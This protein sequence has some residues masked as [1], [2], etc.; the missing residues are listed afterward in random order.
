MSNQTDFDPFRPAD[1]PTPIHDV[2]EIQFDPFWDER[3]RR[4]AGSPCPVCGNGTAVEHGTSA[5][6]RAWIRFSCGDVISRSVTT[7]N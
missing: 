3:E 7:A 2:S 1:P 4:L 5:N 6:N